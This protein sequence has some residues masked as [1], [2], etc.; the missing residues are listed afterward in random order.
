MGAF[1]ACRDRTRPGVAIRDTI[2]TF[3][4]LGAALTA[5]ERDADRDGATVRPWRPGGDGFSHVTTRPDGVS[6]RIRWTGLRP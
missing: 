5:C 2:G 1:Y 3:V 4:S 6:Y